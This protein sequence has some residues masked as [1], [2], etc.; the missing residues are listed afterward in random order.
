MVHSG[1]KIS[2]FTPLYCYHVVFLFSAL[3]VDIVFR[4]VWLEGVC[5]C[6]SHGVVCV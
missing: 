5:Y 1:G 3:Q 2:M 6:G 4:E